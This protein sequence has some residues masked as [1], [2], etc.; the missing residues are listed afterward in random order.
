VIL[1]VLLSLQAI[2][3]SASAGTIYVEPGS[4]IQTAVD[5]AHPGD[6]IIVKPG[7]Y[8]G[9]INI[10]TRNLTIMSSSPCEAIIDAKNNAFNIY[11]SN[12]TIK[13]FDLRGPGKSSGVCFSFSRSEN[14]NGSF[15]CIIENNSISNFSVGA[16][17]G[18]YLCSGSESILN[19]SICNCA[20]GVNAFDLMFESL[21]ICGNHITDCDNGLYLVDAPCV[22]T[23]NNFN[24]TVNV[25]TTDGV[26][27]TFNATNTTGEN[28][29]GGPCVGGNCWANPSGDG[30]SQT[31][32]DSDGDGFVDE[33]Y[34][35]DGS[36]DCVDYLPLVPQKS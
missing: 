33:P 7:T 36:S 14:T 13:N 8:D 30:F 25:N 20:T 3:G 2:I 9:D 11:E 29:V 16:D 5:N 32:S 24:N 17:I 15:F 27:S 28:I 18:Y 19:N 34:Q 10:S 22:V 12:I 6:T 4:S 26:T 1:V 35:L 23:N 31:H 21:T